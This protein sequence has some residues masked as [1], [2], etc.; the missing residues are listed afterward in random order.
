MRWQD[1]KHEAMAPNFVISGK[2]NAYTY[3]EQSRI[4]DLIEAQT[5]QGDMLG[6]NTLPTHSGQDANS[7]ALSTRPPASGYDPSMSSTA[8]RANAFIPAVKK[9]DA[10][11]LIADIDG[12]I[13]AHVR[14][15]EL[16]S[17]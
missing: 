11:Q 13:Q 12:M 6:L 16:Y 7:M 14:K 4:K 5:A 3:E 2:F 17:T 9:L 1:L 10:D 8:Y 15:K